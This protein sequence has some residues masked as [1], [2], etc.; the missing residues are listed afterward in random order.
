MIRCALARLFRSASSWVSLATLI[1]VAVYTTFAGYQWRE[2]IRLNNLTQQSIEISRRALDANERAHLFSTIERFRKSDENLPT[3]IFSLQNFG[4]SPAFSIRYSIACSF[5]PGRP[6]STQPYFIDLILAPG[7]IEKGLKAKC[8]NT[9]KVDTD[10]M[11]AGSRAFYVWLFMQYRDP[12]KTD[13]DRFA[14]ECW[15]K[16]LGVKSPFTRC[17]PG[18]NVYSQ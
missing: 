16:P 13:E 5:E 15:H 9:P 14:L 18:S 17:G 7:K 1:V 12:F 8:W 11:D 6:G 10:V 3:A 4:K 2:M